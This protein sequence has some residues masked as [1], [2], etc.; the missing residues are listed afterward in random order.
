MK[1]SSSGSRMEVNSASSALSRGGIPRALF[2]GG[3]V[4]VWGA[5]RSASARVGETGQ[6]CA[7]IIARRTSPIGMTPSFSPFIGSENSPKASLI[8]ASSCA[9][10]LCSLASFDCRGPFAL[11]SAAGAAG[12]RFAGYV[13]L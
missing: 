4:L 12:R 2:S 3:G 11:G 8:S 10:M 1:P 9:V 6:G 13:N 5:G 7:Y